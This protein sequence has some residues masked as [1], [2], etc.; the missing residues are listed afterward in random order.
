MTTKKVDH[1][2]GIEIWVA[3]PNVANAVKELSTQIKEL[4]TD[5]MDVQIYS[6]EYWANIDR[7]ND[8]SRIYADLLINGDRDGTIAVIEN[9]IYWIED[10]NQSFPDLIWDRVEDLNYIK[11][12]LISEFHI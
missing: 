8:L 4:Q 3:D 9:M 12:I 10:R 7:L 6:D 5:Q 1:K 11:D 2:N